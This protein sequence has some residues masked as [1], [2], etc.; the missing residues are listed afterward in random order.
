[1]LASR[2]GQQSISREGI[3]QAT[4]KLAP[5]LQAQLG[6]L[7]PEGFR[8]LVGLL[9]AP[10]RQFSRTKRELLKT[11][12]EVV[13]R[14]FNALSAPYSCQLEI[15]GN[16]IAIYVDYHG[17]ISRPKVET[18]SISGGADLGENTRFILRDRIEDKQQKCQAAFA[19]G[20]VWLAL[21]NHYWLTDSET[22]RYALSCLEIT[23]SFDAI[24][25]VGEHGEVNPIY[26]R[27]GIA[28]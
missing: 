27:H 20:P 19:A 8:L 1:M 22:Y 25:I 14:G 15:R 5:E 10:L 23:H 17:D 13:S 24:I 12:R 6:A 28:G 4:M 7:I 2:D 11:L 26:M 9:H 3:D 21:F 16:P 18:Y